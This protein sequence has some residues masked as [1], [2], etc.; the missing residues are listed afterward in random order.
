[1]RK[2]QQPT[3]TKINPVAERCVHRSFLKEFKRGE[4]T[5]NYICAECG[6][7]LSTILHT[8]SALS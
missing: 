4:P 5:G 7:H 6:R 8:V 3:I 2:A 1:M